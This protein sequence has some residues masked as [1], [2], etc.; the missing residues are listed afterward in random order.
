MYF[1]ERC[2]RFVRE[3]FYSGNAINPWTQHLYTYTMN[4]PTNF[5][6]P[7]GH[8]ATVALLEMTKAKNA[9]GS[10]ASASLDSMIANAAKDAG[11]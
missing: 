10:K 9:L 1:I 6:D 8:S 5:I 4:N 3:D 7:T 2:L 11:P